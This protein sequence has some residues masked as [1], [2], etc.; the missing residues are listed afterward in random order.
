MYRAGFTAPVIR[1]FLLTQLLLS[2]AGILVGLV[3]LWLS[4]WPLS[5]GVG[6]AIS[7][8]SLWHITRFVQT[9]IQQNFS[10]A[11]GIRL[12]LS[13][14]GRLIFISI[15]LFVFVVLLKA[16]VAPLLVG[17]ASTVA[18]IAIWG[19]LRFSQK[20]VKEA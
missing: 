20:T 13:F 11:L 12:F 9:S 6:I 15:V 5:F 2:A 3:L 19:I 14:T 17:L 18:H 7:T 4:F 16:P 8:Y 10:A 1:H